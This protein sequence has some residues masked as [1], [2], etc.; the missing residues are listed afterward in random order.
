MADD[1]SNILIVDDSQ[2]KL[3]V[4]GSIL[5]EL[6]QNLVFARS[7]E[8]ALRKV[9]ESEFAVI[10]LDVYMPGLDGLETAA[11]IRRR[12]RSAHTPIIFVTA[13]AD[14]MHSARGYS[15]GAVDYILSPVVPGVL[16]TKVKVFVDLHRM[17]QQVKRQADERVALATAEAARAAAEEAT[18]RASFLADAS[19]VL[20]SSLDH[21]TTLRGLLR[22]TVP[23]LADFGA[24]SLAD[25]QG[26]IGSTEIAWGEP[27]GQPDSAMIAPEQIHPRLT[28]ALQD[29][30]A[31]G[32]SSFVPYLDP[33]PESSW[34]WRD[35]PATA[36]GG[37]TL[38]QIALESRGLMPL[39]ARGRVLG[40][41]LLAM[42]PSGRR[43]TPADLLL[44]EDLAGRAAVAID[45]A[46]LYR[47]VQRA[48]THKNEFLSMLA[49]ELRNPLAPIRNAVQILRLR[50]SSD[51]EMCALQD[52]IERQ[53]HHL[54][55]LV[56]DLLDVSR[57]TRGK[58]RLLREP[59]NL[60]T[61]VH[62]ALEICEQMV[63]SRGHKLTLSL[64]EKPVRV[65]GDPVRLAQVVGNLLNNAAK[66][67]LEGGHIW[68]TV[69]REG[70]EAVLRVRDTGVGI[71]PDM[72]GSVFDLFT[73]VECS[74][75]RAHGGLGIGLTLVRQLV[76]LHGGRVQA[77]SAG[78]NQ[79]SEFVVS[80]PALDEPAQVLVSTDLPPA[81]ATARACRRVLVVDDNQ[82]AAESLA[83]VLRIA[84]HEVNVCFDG[85]AAIAAVAATRP[86]V[87]LLDIGLPD[88]N[89]FEVARKLRANADFSDTLLV[90][91]TGYG[92][93]QDMRRSQEAG[94]DHHLV[95]P[96]DLTNLDVIFTSDGRKLAEAALRGELAR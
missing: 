55:R 71:P 27:G 48:D 79:G 73:Q 53:V 6:D 56:D 94:F 95:K 86:D 50:G 72:L 93:E 11:L 24:I 96:I 30:L 13:F 3:L 38:P 9:L 26:Q 14:E 42:G 80:L 32:E 51:P 18:R 61:V 22:L 77:F 36:M 81:I 47:D 19:K 1:K 75:D 33:G 35:N 66:Y 23:Y 60:A 88:M 74:L 78:A 34:P 84:G 4:L 65:A 45:N 15:L 59:L 39:R 64:P 7:G 54:V 70:D 63:G 91:V 5:E 90:A 2:D 43:Y 62:R 25:S 37:E 58:V 20:S 83:M 68:L 57:I 28:A 89:G 69:Q 46:R 16:R 76:E 12:K 8:E 40:V 87:V 44:A 85:P 29:I 17:T 10:L 52:M 31:S 49:H 67:T 41:L 21:E 82:D 92:Q